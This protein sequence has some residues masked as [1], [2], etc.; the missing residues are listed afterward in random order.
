MLSGVNEQNFG[1]S[2]LWNEFCDHPRIRLHKTINF[3]YPLVHVLDDEGR[4]LARRVHS[5]GK[6][7]WRT[8]SPERWEPLPGDFLLEYVFQGDE[9][10]DCFQL[11]LMDSPFN[12]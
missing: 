4:E 2:G 6:W 7:E 1:L 9:K 8:S 11:D 12:S 10:L 5:T 3:G